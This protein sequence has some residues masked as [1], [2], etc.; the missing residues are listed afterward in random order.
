MAAIPIDHE[1]LARARQKRLE[2]KEMLLLMKQMCT[3][4]LFLIFLLFLAQQNRNPNAFLIN[5]NLKN[6]LVDSQFSSVRV[7]VQHE[8]CILL[9][10]SANTK[11]FSAIEQS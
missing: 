6:M 9:A 5:N 3:Y 1:A 4:M 8:H 10:S 11:L 7:F 2:E